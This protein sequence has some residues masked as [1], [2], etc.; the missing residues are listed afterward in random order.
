MIRAHTHGDALGVALLDVR[1]GWLRDGTLAALSRVDPLCWTE[2]VLSPELTLRA[3]TLFEPEETRV[4]ILGQDPYHTPGKAN[5]LAFGYHE[6]WSPRPDASFG[7]IITEVTRSTG[8]VIRD[9][10]FESLARQGVLLLNTRL[11][12]AP[13]IPLSHRALGWEAV[14]EQILQTTRESSPEVLVAA[15]GV[16]AAITA[17]SVFPPEQVLLASHPSPL[18]ASRG[19]RP[20]VGCDHPRILAERTGIQWGER[21]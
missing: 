6:D 3:L 10:T 15:W 8:Q 18:S 5:G 11:S 17:L 14:V 12:V 19:P 2:S 21:G 4:V 7:A 16:E 20:F 13:G 1:N 9:L